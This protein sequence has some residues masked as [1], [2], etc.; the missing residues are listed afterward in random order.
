MTQKLMKRN[1]TALITITALALAGCISSDNRAS[2]EGPGES[3]TDPE[4]AESEQPIVHVT[5]DGTEVDFT[6]THCSPSP[7]N[8]GEM[9]LFAEFADGEITVDAED[10]GVMVTIDM[11]DGSTYYSREANGIDFL[12]GVTQ[13]DV[14]V[15][16]ADDDEM[17][18]GLD[19]T[20]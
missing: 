19:V 11:E 20:C 6:E 12:D 18:V 17:V 7:G 13:G 3:P 15:S 14:E 9:R 4:S 2:H 8:D 1:V 5:F 10:D 16:D